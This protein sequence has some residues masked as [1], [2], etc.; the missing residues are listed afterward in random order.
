MQDA[1]RRLPLSGTGAGARRYLESDTSKADEY[2]LEGGTVLAEL[3][4]VDA[5]G[6][7]VAVACLSPEQYAGWA[8]WTDPLTGESMGRPR[9]AGD[10]KQGSPRFAEMV[11]NA[12][13]SLSTAAALHPEVS[14]VLDEALA[15]AAVQIRGWLAEH[16]VTR[17][18][19]RGR[20][21]VV[22][23]ERLQS[24]QVSHK[25]S[26][27][28]DP[29]R[30]VH[31]QIGTRVWAA[32]AWRAL[33]TAALF[34]QQGAIR[35]L[36]TAVIA[37]HPRLAAVLDAHGLTLDPVTGEVAE[38]E[39][40]NATMSKRGEQVTRNFN[41]FLAGW[42][43]KHPGQEPSRSATARLLSMAWDHE[44][45]AKR[46]SARLG[47]EARWRA[48]L[49]EAGYTPNPPRIPRP[50]A[51]SLDDLSIEDIARRALDRVAAARSAWTRHD[52]QENATRLLTEYGVRAAPKEIARFVELATRLALEDTF[53]ILPPGAPAPEHVAHLTSLHVVQVETALRDLLSARVQQRATATPDVTAL[54]KAA[55]LDRGQARAAAAIASTESLVVVE[56]AA[57]AGKTTMLG[58]AIQ[59]A[60]AEGRR[61]RVVTP[62]KK[63]ADVARQE[64]GVPT[65]SV[66]KL[67]HEHGWRW[68]DDG[69]WTRLHPGETDPETGALYRGPS[70]SARLV[71]GERVVVDEAGMLDQ[72]TTLALL[73]VTAETGATVA[74][75]GDRAQ[76]PQ[77]G[78]GGVLD[79]AA[80]I[81]GVVHDMDTVHRFADPAYA[82]LTV[83]MRAGDN[84][85]ALFDELV[86]MGLVRLHESAEA[87][88][89]AIAADVLPGMAV[90]VAT[91]DEARALNEIVRARRVAE[92]NVDDTLTLPGTDGLPIGAGDVIQT[93]QNDSE[94][95]A[96]NRQTW[97]VQKVDP[98][99][100]WVRELGGGAKARTVA[101]PADYVAA[102]AHLAYA[103]TTYGVQ[104]ATVNRSHT[105]LSDAMSAS[106]VY[107]GMTRGR[108]SNQLHVV[109]TDLE[110]AREQFQSGLE[111]DTADR[112]L[113]HATQKAV[114]AV[115]G[116][117]PAWAV[118]AVALG[119]TM[120]TER[121]TDARRQEAHWR[122]EATRASQPDYARLIAEHAETWKGRV[123][124]AQHALDTFAALP[125]EDAAGLVVKHEID[126]RAQHL[127]NAGHD[128]LTE[129]AMTRSVEHDQ[130]PRLGM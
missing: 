73:T 127:R 82:A 47:S 43:A 93:R 126:R 48:E 44:R 109:A 121:I 69:V 21:A 29:H 22:P 14:E 96:A 25:T 54:A 129:Q 16:S 61:V 30:H 24:V 105:V 125:V 99:G 111:R 77:V 1:R 10:G 81:K 7:V 70:T 53:S 76:L 116:L 79:M 15:D 37:A 97:T 95:G 28:G 92:G 120:L 117:A 27:A 4:V 78:R 113:T 94:L 33:D 2:Y 80:Q 90:S 55:G 87:A 46:A 75:V 59:A 50:A 119:R 107:V 40:F 62:S 106:G 63:A 41:R 112:G 67:V 114:E 26:R 42:E 91:N 12:P 3:T 60:A 64:L 72:D 84:P 66:A 51:R 49:A 6:E 39:R 56:G 9:G 128:A 88:R 34:K 83:R 89:D 45:P 122:R 104:G 101:L 36:G 52:V 124:Q 74:L 103:V 123:E 58:V 98:G 38:L 31:F 102:S 17:V 100:M 13:K 110:D 118:Q 19:P 35:A 108:E 18:G 11:V 68:N 86:A 20:Q 23:V 65:D 32:G 57:G 71:P 5:A 130:G 115:A 8:D 85:D